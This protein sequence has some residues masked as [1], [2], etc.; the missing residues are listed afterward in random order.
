MNYNLL[1][2]LGLDSTMNQKDIQQLDQ[3][4]NC[5]VQGSSGKKLPKMTITERNNLISKLSNTTLN[6]IPKKELKDMDEQEKKIHKEELRQKLKNKL[7]YFVK[8]IEL[9]NI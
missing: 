1:N 5:M 9:F 2:N 6:E 4:L 8:L 7:I 3:I